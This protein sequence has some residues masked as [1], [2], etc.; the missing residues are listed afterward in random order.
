MQ[1]F[2]ISRIPA[3]RYPSYDRRKRQQAVRGAETAPRN[4]ACYDTRPEG[5]RIGRSDF[6]SR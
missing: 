3:G 6:R 5:H 4:C 2:R 1:P